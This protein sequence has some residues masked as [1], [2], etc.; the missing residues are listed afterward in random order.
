MKKYALTTTSRLI[1]GKPAYQIK[2][3]VNIDRFGVKAGDLGGFVSGEDNLSQKGD[4]WIRQTSYAL[5]RS[6]VSGNALL[7]DRSIVKDEAVITDNAIVSKQS[8]VSGKAMVSGDAQVMRQSHVSDNAR[9]YDEAIVDDRSTVS[10]RGRVFGQA[11]VTADSHVSHYAEACEQAAI[12]HGARLKDEAKAFGSAYVNAITLDFRVEVS[13][14]SRA[15]QN[16]PGKPEE[17]RWHNSDAFASLRKDLIA[18]IND[19]TEIREN[20][21]RTGKHY[22]G[23][24]LQMNLAEMT[25]VMG[26]AGW[27]RPMSRAELG[28][29]NPD[30]VRLARMFADCTMAR[31]TIGG[32]VQYYKGKDALKNVTDELRLVNHHADMQPWVTKP[33]TINRQAMIREIETMPI[34]K[35]L[36]AIQAVENVRSVNINR[37]KARVAARNH[38]DRMTQRPPQQRSDAG[39]SL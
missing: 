14:G 19:Q 37:A 29:Q 31:S 36:T 6:R 17:V 35:V 16:P 9:I 20:G 22:P 27:T 23:F 1:D 5:D 8:S 3:L 21:H 4:C 18:R 38:R 24:Q 7:A 12:A 10:G 39:M 28:T 13:G 11:M 25:E 26:E 15:F 2:A 33:L 30:L 32:E 34:Y